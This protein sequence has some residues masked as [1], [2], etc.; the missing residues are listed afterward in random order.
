MEECGSANPSRV[1]RHL[2][3]S[4][5]HKRGFHMQ[6]SSLSLRWFGKEVM[7]IAVS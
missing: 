2:H 7:N 4:P 3:P 6:G 5:L 1:I